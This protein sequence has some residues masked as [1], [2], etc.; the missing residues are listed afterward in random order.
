M[1]KPNGRRNNILARMLQIEA[2]RYIARDVQKLA[3][4]HDFQKL[5]LLYSGR[6]GRC[7]SGCSSGASLAAAG[8]RCSFRRHAATAGPVPGARGGSGLPRCRGRGRRRRRFSCG[9]RRRLL[10]LAA[11]LLVGYAPRLGVR[12]ADVAEVDPHGARRE[13]VGLRRV[14]ALLVRGAQ[15]ADERVEGPPGLA[16]RARAGRR[17]VRLA[18]VGAPGGVHLGLAELVQV[19]EELDDVRAAAPR[20]RERRPVVPQVLQERVPVPPLLRF[21]PAELRRRSGLLRLRLR[22]SQRL[23]LMLRR[24]ERVVAAPR[25]RGRPGWPRGIHARRRSSSYCSPGRPPGPGRGRARDRA[26]QWRR[27]PYP[28][29]AP[30][31]VAMGC[32]GERRAG[33]SGEREVN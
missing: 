13:G 6:A 28:G 33:G 21:V 7:R 12:V 23:D 17:R 31:W 20:Q 15:A 11:L 25:R 3:D 14:A 1:P 2:R 24:R 5:V 8:G 19:L 18:E 10:A 26:D 4:R 29:R 32:G 30:G 16:Q 22:L 9:R 27:A